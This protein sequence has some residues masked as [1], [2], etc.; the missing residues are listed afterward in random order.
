MKV[1][2][3]FYEFS[4]LTENCWSGAIQTLDT[5]TE[6]DKKEGL[7]Q[8]LEEVFYDGIELTELNDFL[9]FDSDYIFECLDIYGVTDFDLKHMDLIG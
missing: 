4:D 5:I 2:T 6:H 7:M 1:Y 3:D 9:W 8:L